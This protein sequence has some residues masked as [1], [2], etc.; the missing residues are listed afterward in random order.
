M[1]SEA[2]AFLSLPQFLI[3]LGLFY[4]I[5]RFCKE[6]EEKLR[7]EAKIQI[8]MWLAGTKTVEKVERWPETFVTVFERIFGTEPLSWT[9]F[10]RSAL[11]T[12]INLTVISVFFTHSALSNISLVGEYPIL[13]AHPITTYLLIAPVSI[14]LQT[15]FMS[16][17]NIGPD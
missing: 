9:C 6:V 14:L 2:T 11:A 3:G 12:I 15:L 10:R 7:P 8:W 1:V 13:Q 17:F 16:V 4:G 5:Q